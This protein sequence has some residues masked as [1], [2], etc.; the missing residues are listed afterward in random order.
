MSYAGVVVLGLLLATALFSIHIALEFSVLRAKVVAT[1]S[2]IGLQFLLNRFVVFRLPTG[3]EIA[4]RFGA[5]R[6]PGIA[7]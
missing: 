2:A 3:K 4:G 7:E 1:S 6:A 5:R